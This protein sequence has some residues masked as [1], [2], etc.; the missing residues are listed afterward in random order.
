MKT[1]SLIL[2]IVG[3]GISAAALRGFVSEKETLV[4][5]GKLELY[6]IRLGSGVPPNSDCSESYAY[7]GCDSFEL[8]DGRSFKTMACHIPLPKESADLGLTVTVCIG[9]INKK[10]GRVQVSVPPY[11]EETNSTQLAILKNLNSK[12][13]NQGTL[14]YPAVGVA[15]G[16]VYDFEFEDETVY[17]SAWIGSLEIVLA[18]EA[19]EAMLAKEFEQR[20]DDAWSAAEMTAESK[21]NSLKLGL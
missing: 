5:P 18:S 4:A 12:F 16:R 6:G 14:S 15:M 21:S 9:D 20:S 3:V 10:I 11:R 1:M 17:A 19:S 7:K 2:F 13:H 8:K